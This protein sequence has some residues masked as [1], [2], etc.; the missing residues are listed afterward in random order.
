MTER[1]RL[2]QFMIDAK[3]NDPE[4][5]PWSEW[6]VD[7][8]FDHGVIVPPVKVGDTVY[9]HDFCQTDD[10]EGFYEA[11]PVIV[12]Q[13]SISNKGVWVDCSYP[14]DRTAH[15]LS[16]FGKTLFLTKEEAE[17]AL[18]EREQNG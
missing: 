17:A 6:L 18:K 16:A 10:T 9:A 1:E 14:A 8:L 13:I 5:K 12:E 11:V 15:L 3:R 7:Y 4:T 2:M